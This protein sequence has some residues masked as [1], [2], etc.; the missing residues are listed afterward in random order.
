MSS[1]PA[2]ASYGAIVLWRLVDQSGMAPLSITE[3]FT[4]PEVP[5]SGFHCCT[6]HPITPLCHRVRQH[7]CDRRGR[8]CSSS[9]VYHGQLPREFLLQVKVHEP[10]ALLNHAGFSGSGSQSSF[11][12]WQK[13]VSCCLRVQTR[14]NTD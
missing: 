13:T 9:Y 4:A 11:G 7:L 6:M 2:Y 3:A 5:A 14:Y 1:D 12:P 10:P 8:R